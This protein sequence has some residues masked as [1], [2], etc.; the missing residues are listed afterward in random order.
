MARLIRRPAFRP[1]LVALED[2]RTPASFVVTTLADAGPGS[3]RDA[4][5]LAN[6]APGP[7]SISFAKTGTVTLT[8]GKLLVTDSLAVNGPGATLLTVNGNNAGSIFVL[9]GP[10][11]LDVAI[12]GL[13]LTGGDAAKDGNFSGGAIHSVG[14]KLTLDAVAVI[15]NKAQTGGGVAVSKSGT[16]TVVNSTVSGN[17]SQ[18]TGGGILGDSYGGA[19]SITVTNSTITGNKAAGLGG[20]IGL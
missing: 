7:D 19:V 4:I 14:E 10:G 1:R 16:L 13:T 2:R 20:G 5:A 3:L 18:F 15:G 11:V 17:S 8:T 9:D 6:A 12:S